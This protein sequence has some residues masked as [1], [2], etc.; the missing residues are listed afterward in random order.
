M[1][2]PPPIPSSGAQGGIT[3]LHSA[4][5]IGYIYIGSLEVVKTL[6]ASGAD[7]KA[8]TNVSETI[9]GFRL[10]VVRLEVGG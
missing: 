4:C 6:V 8:K 10:T 7:V 3:P 1:D 5:Y 2:I 9:A